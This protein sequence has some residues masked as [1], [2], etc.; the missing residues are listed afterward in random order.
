[1]KA[2]A[3]PFHFAIFSFSD[4]KKPFRSMIDKDNVPVLLTGRP[5]VDS[6]LR[7]LET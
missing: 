1:M 6:S 2:G 3:Y 5:N 7:P 4:S